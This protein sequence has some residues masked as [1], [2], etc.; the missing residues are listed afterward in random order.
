MGGKQFIKNHVR[1]DLLPR[2][3][4]FLEGNID[5][6]CF[7]SQGTCPLTCPASPQDYNHLLHGEE[8]PRAPPVVNLEFEGEPA[9]PD[10]FVGLLPA[11]VPEVHGQDEPDHLWDDVAAF[12]Q[13]Q[14]CS[15]LGTEG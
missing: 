15:F 1:V 5:E 10:G 2:L 12:L 14:V 4:L 3:P 7:S 9:V 11:E 6:L 8:I 13:E